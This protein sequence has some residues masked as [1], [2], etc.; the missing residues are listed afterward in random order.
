M[1]HGDE[2]VAR[3]RPV[4]A[5]R[6]GVDRRAVERRAVA[7]VLRRRRRRPV[8]GHQHLGRHRGRRVL[9]VAARRAAAVAVLARRPRARHGRRRVRRRRPTGARRGR[10]ARVHEAVAGH[11]PRAC[12]TTR[13]RY[14]ETYWS[15]WPGRVVARRLRERDRRRPVVPARP[16]RRHDQGRGQ[17]ARAGRGRDRASSA[18]PRCSRRPRSACPTTLKGEALWVFVVRRARASTPTT[19]CATSCARASPSTSGPSFR[20][21][22]GALHRRAARRRAAPRCCA[23]RSARSSP[24]TRPATCPASRIPR[25]SMRSRR[26]A[27]MTELV[28]ARVVLRPLRADD[29]DAWREV[30]HALPRVARA[31]GAAA[32]ARERRS[33]RSTARRSAPAAARGSASATSTPRTASACSSPTAASPAR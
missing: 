20:P 8:P 21:V 25:R 19:R 4:V 12:G 9:P 17:A 14:L 18:I 32:R 3:A 29:W 5:A 22:G 30:R 26:R 1:A 2:P 33:R 16:L 23:A 10:R 6:P 7:L 28:G 27:D 15:R 31:V 13:E 11:D 24:A